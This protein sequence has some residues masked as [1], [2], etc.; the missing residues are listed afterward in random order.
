MEFYQLSLS[1][2]VRAN[3][4]SGAG[5]Q[6]KCAEWVSAE[7]LSLHMYVPLLRT[8]LHRLHYWRSPP[9]YAHPQWRFCIDNIN[10]CSSFEN[11]FPTSC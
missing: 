10:H 3:S 5:K 7:V 9:P 11:I 2:S 4:T 6:Q 1:L 8:P